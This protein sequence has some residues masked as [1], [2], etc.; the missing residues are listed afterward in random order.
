MVVAM[1]VISVVIVLMRRFPLS[2]R[3][4]VRTWLVLPRRSVFLPGTLLP[5][6]AGSRALRAGTFVLGQATLFNSIVVHR[7]SSF[8]VVDP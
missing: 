7:L 4:Q 2:A 3:A 1:G 5:S 6:W 8:H